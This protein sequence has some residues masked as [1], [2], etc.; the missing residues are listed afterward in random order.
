MLRQR[1]TGRPDPPDRGTSRPAQPWE[2]P[3]VWP[4]V[5]WD[6]RP[7]QAVLTPPAG[8][9]TGVLTCRSVVE[10]RLGTDRVLI[11]V[12]GKAVYVLNP[13]AWGVWEL[14]DGRRSADEIVAE[15]ARRYRIPDHTAAP[16]CRQV[17]AML[18]AADLIIRAER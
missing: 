1:R 6:G 11:D 3:R 5:S 4:V 8:A 7:Q 14:S 12:T 16:A 17:L 9:T 10:R 18:E 15:L 2:E 13:T